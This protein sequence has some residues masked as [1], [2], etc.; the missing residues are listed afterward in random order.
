METENSTRA[1]L[2]I[3]GG[4]LLIGLAIGAIVFIG[5]PTVGANGS[6]A[7]G[8]GGGT[9]APAPIVGSPAPDFS[10]ANLKGQSITLSELKGKPV[11]IN[12][13]ATWC[14]P[15]RVEMPAIQTAF[16]AHKGEGFTVL[17]VDADEPLADVEKFFSDL[18]LTF[19][20]LL[21]PDLVVND[22]YRIMAYPSSFF[23]GRDGAIAAF[24]IGSMTDSQLADNL[25]KILK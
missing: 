23:V 1:T 12:F 6:A 18:N 10:L 2:L 13:W 22:Q 16:E 8:V 19:E 9:P 15:C 7:T 14:G 25:A 24:Q 17:A 5:L 20:A 3:L 21:D 11:L 4:G